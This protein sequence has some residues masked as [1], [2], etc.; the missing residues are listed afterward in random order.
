M[1]PEK[2]NLIDKAKR[3]YH[4]LLEEDTSTAK[5][6]GAGTVEVTMESACL[7]VGL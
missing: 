4:A 6:L 7:R 2:E 1:M 5:A 3:T